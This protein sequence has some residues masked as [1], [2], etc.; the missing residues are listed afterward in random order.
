MTTL[1]TVKAAH[2]KLNCGEFDFDDNKPNEANNEGVVSIWLD[3]DYK[4][5]FAASNAT[6]ICGTYW[7]DVKGS[8][9][10]ALNHLIEDIK[11]GLEPMSD[12][13]ACACGIDL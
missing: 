12:D 3:A 9:E 10:D 5:Q 13:T 7:S 4:K 8:R 1:A 6:I 11:H 2:A